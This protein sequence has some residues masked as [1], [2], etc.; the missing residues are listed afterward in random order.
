MGLIRDAARSTRG[1]I[2]IGAIVAFLLWKAGLALLAPR[3]VTGAFTP[4]A[5][6]QVNVLVTLHCT[7]EHFHV[8]AFQQFGRVSGTQDNSIEVRG[9]SAADLNAVARPYWVARVEP[10]PA[11]K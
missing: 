5:R 2:V 8:L 10:L 4:N 7:P 1:R 9:V 11:E 6:G 3:K